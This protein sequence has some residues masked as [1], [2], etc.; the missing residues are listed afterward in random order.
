MGFSE[1]LPNGEKGNLITPEPDN[2]MECVEIMTDLQQQH[3]F[4]NTPW[5]HFAGTMHND[6]TFLIKFKNIPDSDSSQGLIMNGISELSLEEAIDKFI[7]E[8]DWKKCV[9][10]RQ[11]NHPKP[12]PILTITPILKDGQTRPDEFVM[13]Y[14]ADG[15]VIATETLENTLSISEWMVQPTSKPKALVYDL[16]EGL[17]GVV[18]QILLQL[19]EPQ[20]EELYCDLIIDDYA[21]V[22]QLWCVNKE[23]QH[24][25]LPMSGLLNG[26]SVDEAKKIIH[27]KLTEI[28]RLDQQDNDIWNKMQ[29]CAYPSGGV[30][31]ATEWQDYDQLLEQKD[32]LKRWLK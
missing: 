27:E 17:Y 1:V 12:Y 8:K 22:M 29:I 21:S 23:K 25:S 28:H 2:Y 10:E 6:G 14:I 19:L 18:G 4:K 20:M 9:A 30:Q 26:F 24:I 32:Q 5:N 15:Q 7:S 13:Q 16:E 31:L 11:K 3:L